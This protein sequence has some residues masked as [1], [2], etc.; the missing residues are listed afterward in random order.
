MFD[1]E[2]TV[3]DSVLYYINTER[4]KLTT[5]NTVLNASALYKTET[6]RKSKELILEICIE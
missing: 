4:D 1:L 5:D 3:V 2:N 6:V